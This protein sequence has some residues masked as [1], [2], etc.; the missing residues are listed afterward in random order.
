MF[1]RLFDRSTIQFCKSPKKR[2]FT[3]IHF[4]ILAGSYERI[5]TNENKACSEKEIDKPL[6]KDINTV[7]LCEAS[8][9]QVPNCNFFVMNSRNVCKLFEQCDESK[10]KSSKN[11]RSIYKKIE[12]N[13]NNILPI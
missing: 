2:N 11:S 13:L 8:C 5:I 4:F 12:G 1:I 6:K 9:N 7:T 10:I 3:S